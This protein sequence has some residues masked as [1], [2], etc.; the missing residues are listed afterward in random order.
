MP[1]SPAPR[2]FL[3]HAASEDD[4]PA[5]V[6][7]GR[8]FAVFVALAALITGGLWWFLRAHEV[9][10][11][12][13]AGASQPSTGRLVYT[14]GRPGDQQ[15]WIWDPPAAG[16]TPG[17]ALDAEVE[18]LVGA[19]G[20]LAGVL[21]VTTRD[22]EGLLTASVLR[23]QAAGARAER[24]ATAELVSWGPSGA[25]VVSA[26]LGQAR[27]GC[28]ADVTMI[29]ARLD[30]GVRDQVFHRRGLCG[31]ISGLGQTFASTY[32]TW[33]R[34]DGTGVFT[35]SDRE[36]DVVLRGWSLLAASPTSDLIVEP[37]AGPAGGSGA[38]VFRRGTEGPDPYRSDAGGP[39]GV[40]RILAW[41]TEADAALV[42]ATA[43]GRDGLYLLDTRPGGDRV[44]VYV[45]L[46]QTP[47]FATATFDGS[48]YIAQ[49]GNLLIWRDGHLSD[50][51]LP[52]DAPRPTGPL[53]WLPG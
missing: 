8:P 33:E 48:L 4:G 53:A 39:V 23:T 9:A 18:Q 28:Y 11:D 37:V 45:G 30:R 38:A 2:R 10:G 35:V 25:S 20:G 49:Q 40:R 47:A 31:Q 17:P 22:D 21:G 1:A 3:A 34:D 12:A 7:R 5:P 32:F 19:Q 26:N 14:A 41:T 52:S 24:V 13:D 42:E 27:S 36:P 50:A 51:G 46:A 16:A 15:L 6:R 29:R 43:D 44:P